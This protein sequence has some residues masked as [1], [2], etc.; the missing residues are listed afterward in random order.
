MEPTT[1]ERCFLEL[2]SLNADMFQLFVDAFVH[3][4]PDSLN[5]LGWTTV[6]YIRPSADP[7]GEYTAAVLPPYGPELSPIERVWRDVKDALAW[8]QFPDLDA[9]QD[10][11]STLLRASEADTLQSLTGYSYLLDAIYG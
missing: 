9:Q 8:Q 10:R 1:G 5:I 6:G 4:F 11:L 7:S 3:A 2:P